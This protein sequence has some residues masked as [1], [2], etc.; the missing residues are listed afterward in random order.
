MRGTWADAECICLASWRGEDVEAHE[1]S[2]CEV[3]L[4]K[5]AGS[6]SLKATRRFNFTFELEY[7]YFWIDRKEE[8]AK[9]SSAFRAGLFRQ[10]PR[11]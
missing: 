5:A 8:F 1:T 4:E 11:R 3:E 2:F 6:A 10:C 7:L 9:L